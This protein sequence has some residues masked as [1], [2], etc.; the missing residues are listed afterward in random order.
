MNHD[1]YKNASTGDSWTEGFAEFFSLVVNREIAQDGTP[2]QVYS[3]A[4]SASNLEANWMSWGFHGA[5]SF[6]EFAVASLLWDLLDPADAKDKTVLTQRGAGGVKTATYADRVE[7]PLPTLWSH[8]A[9]DPGGAY[10]YNLH[11]QNLYE[12]LKANGVGAAVS[13]E[14]AP[15]FG[16]AGLTALDELFV[17]HG[18]FADTGPYR[19]YFDAGRWSVRPDTCRIP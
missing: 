15:E 1:G 2:P 4:G 8:L 3:W 17:A 16:A 11:M 14:A 10:G 13:S 18:F 5:Q 6:E 12:V 19:G 7:I 9:H